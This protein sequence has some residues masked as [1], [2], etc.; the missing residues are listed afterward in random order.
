MDL[1][2]FSFKVFCA[3]LLLNEE[4]T[5]KQPSILEKLEQM[6]KVDGRSSFER[7]RCFLTRFTNKIKKEKRKE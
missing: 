6:S 7:L 2:R 4:N 1:S 5:I 3:I